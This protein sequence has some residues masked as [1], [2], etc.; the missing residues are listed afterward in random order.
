VITS[1]PEGQLCQAFDPMMTLEVKNFFND[2]RQMSTSC[3]AP[4]YVYLEGT[5]GKRFLCDF[6]YFYEK[7]ITQVYSKSE[8]A[9]VESFIYEELEKIKETFN[10]NVKI[11]RKFTDC[12]CGAESS[13]RYWCGNTVVDS[14]N[15][16]YR[17]QYYRAL[18]NGI[19]WKENHII[20]DQRIFMEKTIEEEA[21]SLPLS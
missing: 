2:G 17:K 5:R 14:C 1:I 9:K 7:R 18:V 4:A 6:H 11:R 12:W 10:K 21:M 19:V 20:N 15:F 3:I 13:I 8:W 16:H